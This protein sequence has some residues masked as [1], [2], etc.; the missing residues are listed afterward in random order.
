MSVWVATIT[1]TDKYI[2]L[3]L[4]RRRGDVEEVDAR[5]CAERLR[6]LIKEGAALKVSD[7]EGRDKVLSLNLYF[8]K[9]PK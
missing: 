3:N 7:D 6:L 8:F 4:A 1:P 9:K 5:N 2:K